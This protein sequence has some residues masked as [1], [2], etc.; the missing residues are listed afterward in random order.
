LVFIGINLP[1]PQPT[2]LLL[3]STTGGVSFC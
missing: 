2:S 3:I 1:L